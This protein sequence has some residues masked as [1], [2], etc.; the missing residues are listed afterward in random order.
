MTQDTIIWT[1][2]TKSSVVSKCCTSWSYQIYMNIIRGKIWGGILILC[3][4]RE[5]STLI[6]KDP[7]VS[8]SNESYGDIFM[9]PL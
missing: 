7:H 9:F 3:Q 6:G 1:L 5:P 4:N 2:N 8:K